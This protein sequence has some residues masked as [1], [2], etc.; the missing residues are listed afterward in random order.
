M[1]L[2]VD[3]E[4]FHDGIEEFLESQEFAD[5]LRKVTSPLWEN[6]L[7][8]PV[9]GVFLLIVI[10][11]IPTGKYTKTGLRAVKRVLTGEVF[12]NEFEKFHKRRDDIVGMLACVIMAGT[13]LE[14]GRHASLVVASF[15][16]D[17]P[18]ELLGKLTS[19]YYQ[20]YSADEGQTKHVKLRELLRD[21]QYKTHRR[22]LVPSRY[23]KGYK[24]YFL[25]LPLSL[26]EVKLV[27]ERGFIALV[28]VPGKT[29]PI[30]QVPITWVAPA[31]S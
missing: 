5:R 13:Q 22:R 16:Q 31:F 1:G 18:P 24:L 3:Y 4:R 28:G 10:L 26:D 17:V 8:F 30:M 15:E 2:R 29:G 27:G 21:H 12:R 11:M 7:F 23:S 14:D 6:I 19:S 20:V 9:G 25:D